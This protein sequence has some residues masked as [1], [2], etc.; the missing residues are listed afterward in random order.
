MSVR[1]ARRVTASV[2]ATPAPPSPRGPG[3]QE[4]LKAYHRARD[5]G[6]DR[7]DFA[8][9]IQFLR[10]AGLSPTDLRQ[11]IAQGFVE[12]RTGTSRS[13]ARRRA[14]ARPIPFRFSERSCFILTDRGAAA[15][16]ATVRRTL[17]PFYD[18]TTRE[19]WFDGRLV[20][21]F[22]RPAPDQVLILKAFQEQNWVRRIDDPLPPRPGRVPTQRLPRA[23]DRLNGCQ[24]EGRLKFHGDGTARGITW[25][26]G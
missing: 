19:L 12:H 25:E 4:L 24:K 8:L 13:G 2:P 17:V 6:R 9:Q 15:V 23:I 14:F 10:H 16:S 1:P 11:L 20:K 18:E 3:L 5:L 22:K 7:W 26:P 21:R